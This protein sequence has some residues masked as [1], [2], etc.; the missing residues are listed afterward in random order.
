[1]CEGAD[2]LSSGR[3]LS[4]SLLIGQYMRRTNSCAAAEHLPA[5]CELK[6]HMCSAVDQ[7]RRVAALHWHPSLLKVHLGRGR[8]THPDFARL[9]SST[10][11]ASLV[12]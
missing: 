10:L 7:R 5:G 6:M 1:M 2:L 12:S 9:L 4:F 8:Q 11:L 3:L